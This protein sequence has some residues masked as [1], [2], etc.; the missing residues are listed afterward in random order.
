MEE[1]GRNDPHRTGPDDR[2]EHQVPAVAM[3]YSILK[4][5]KEDGG[6]QEETAEDA[7]DEVARGK[8]G[9]T[10]LIIKDEKED[11][12]F[13]TVVPAKGPARPWTARR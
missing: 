6:G 4:S 3:D 2:E 9:S 13:A 8:C 11:K 1:R 10:M 12:E 7:D 5:K